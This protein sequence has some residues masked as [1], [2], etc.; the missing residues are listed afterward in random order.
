MK[1]VRYSGR[2]KKDFR[3]IERRGYDLPKLA[4]VIDA[5]RDG[6]PLPPAARPHSLKGAWSGYD[7]CHIGGDWLLI[8][9]NH[10]TELLLAATGTHS[11]LF[12][13]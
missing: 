3:R 12:D 10:P 4:A 5:L 6:L 13:E 11:D 8:Y 7:E 9:T 2:F 1:P